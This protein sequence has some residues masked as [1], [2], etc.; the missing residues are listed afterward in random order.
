MEECTHYEKTGH[1]TYFVTLTH[2][3]ATIPRVLDHD[4]CPQ[5]TLRKRWFLRWL[6][7]TQR[8]TCGRFHYYA[9]GEYG[10]RYGRPHYHLALFPEYFGQVRDFQEAW[11]RGR[12]EATPLS[13]ERARYLANYTAKK[14]TKDSD[15]RLGPDQ[16]P[17]FRTSSRHPPLG[18]DFAKKLIDYYSHPKRQELVKRR[19][20]IERTWR[21]ENR[22]YPIPD[23]VLTQVRKSL[24]IPLRH[25]DRAL[26]NPDYLDY[27]ET[28]EAIYCPEE[29]K[30]WETQLNAQTQRKI[31]RTPH[32][33][34]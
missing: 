2:S 11:Q 1:L 16:E 6:K 13:H 31:Y 26:E 7:D 24:G 30:Q 21:V 12:T 18:Y 25:C 34:L 14:L 17:E 4:A 10:E 20:D 23:Y 5:G 33:R 29:A 22:I 28:Q 27:H 3:E 8:R 9:V 15:E 19:G 32:E